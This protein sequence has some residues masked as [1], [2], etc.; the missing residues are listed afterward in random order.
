MAQLKQEQELLNSK[1]VSDLYQL[2]TMPNLLCFGSNLTIN[3][4]RW[5]SVLQNII[6]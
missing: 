2:D 5:S 4:F 3:H 1:P 6:I